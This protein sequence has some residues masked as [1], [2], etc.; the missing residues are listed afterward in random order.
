[1]KFNQCNT[2][3]SK[4]TVLSQ[5]CQVQ[6]SNVTMLQC[7]SVT[8]H[9]RAESQEKYVNYHKLILLYSESAIVVT[10]M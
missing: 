7:Y 9:P 4:V 10:L 6:K 3:V 5:I 1:M 2:D 8:S